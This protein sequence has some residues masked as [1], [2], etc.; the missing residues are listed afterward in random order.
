MSKNQIIKSYVLDFVFFI[1]D[2]FIFENNYYLFNILV[3]KKLLYE[4]KI[5][6]FLKK[7]ENYY[8]KNKYFYITRNPI[9]YNQFNTVLKQI[10][11]KNNIQISIIKK[12]IRSKYNTELC[13]FCKND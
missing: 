13:I 12:Y 8:Y 10:C 1:K 11:K 7:L 4:E 9:T 5:Y 2:N 3:F 6:T